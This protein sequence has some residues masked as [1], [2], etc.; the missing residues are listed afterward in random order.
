MIKP[1]Y[2]VLLGDNKVV[3]S[4]WY[5]VIATSEEEAK[6]KL[7]NQFY[8]SCEAL[9]IVDCHVHHQNVIC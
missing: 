8:V 1:C 6:V 5:Y 3:G 7:A 9:N 2:A 4:G